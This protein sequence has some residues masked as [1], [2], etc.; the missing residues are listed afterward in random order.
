M[1]VRATCAKAL[2][3]VGRDEDADVLAPLAADSDAR[4]AAEAART[5][6]K[7]AGKCA[8][9]GCRALHTLQD[10][11]CRGARRWCRQ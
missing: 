7:L 5:L 1:H 6:V 9:A 3:E 11:R 10:L 8:D 4:V 2:A